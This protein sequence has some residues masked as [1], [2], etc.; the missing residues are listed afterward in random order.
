M[1]KKELDSD[2]AQVE[3]LFVTLD[4][5]KGQPEKLAGFVA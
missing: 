1:M 2:S 3:V 5:A 4:P